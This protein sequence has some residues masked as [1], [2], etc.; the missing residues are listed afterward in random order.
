MW[1]ST[2]SRY[3]LREVLSLT[4]I[5]LISSTMIIMLGVV[6]HQLLSAGLGIR[7]FLQMLPYA[8][9]I[10]LQFAVPSSLLFAVCSVYGRMAADNELTAVKGAGVHPFRAIVPVYVLGLVA[11]PFV[12][13]VN[14]VAVSW[15]RPGLNKIVLHSIE[16]IAYGLLRSKGTYRANNLNIHVE[17]VQD[18]WLI[19][20]TI[21]LNVGN[22]TNTIEA[23]KASISLNEKNETLAIELV[24]WQ[25]ENGKQWQMYGGKDPNRF[26]LPLEMA[27]RK[28]Q[29][30]TASTSELALSEMPVARANLTREA[31]TFE[32]AL[33]SRSSTSMLTGQFGMFNDPITSDHR[34]RLQEVSKRSF[35]LQQEPWRRW[36]LG[37][38]C[39]SFVVVGAPLAIWGRSANYSTSFALCFLPILLGYYPLFAA[40]VDF[41]KNGAWPPYSPFL[42][43]VLMVVVGIIFLRKVYRS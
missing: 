9:V 38:S 19:H 6:M 33:I 4:T 12:V 8:T 20:P 5:M 34:Y 14:D 32:Q 13:W 2:F 15:G 10:S 27:A 36:A 41:A 11:S 24:N 39:L 30:I 21:C 26:E 42:A 29:A 7:A 37:F 40:G 28:G 16:E 31:N 43:N 1:P 25:M 35:R 18:R 3:I 22:D 23:E 17:D